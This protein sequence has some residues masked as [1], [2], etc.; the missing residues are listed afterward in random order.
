[1][2]TNPLK[3]CQIL[4]FDLF[5]TV[6]D[7]GTSLNPW[8]EAFLAP[9]KTTNQADSKSFWNLMRHRQRIEQYQDT[10]LELKHSGYLETARKAFIYTAR[11]NHIQPTDMEIDKFMEG[12]ENLQVFPDCFPALNQLNE[13]FNLV[14]LSNGNKWYLEYLARN[15][16]EFDF[17]KIISVEEV[18]VF[19][20]HPAVYRQAA[21]MLNVDPGKIAMVSSNSFDVMGARACGLRGIFVNR[22]DLP[23]EETEKLFQPDLVVK[24]FIQLTQS[25]THENQNH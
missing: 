21:R 24:D 7:L 17:F 15:Q 12:W 19:K 16:I 11:L 2:N 22:H 9:H 25:L 18:G 14:A 6:L 8:I 5:D 23:F 10:L 13:S 20:P 3:N 4:T 1:L